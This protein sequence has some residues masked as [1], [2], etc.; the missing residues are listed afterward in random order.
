[1]SEAWI[2]AAAIAVLL[3]LLAPLAR[4]VR[5]QAVMIVAAMSMMLAC[6][7]ALVLTGEP[8]RG[9]HGLFPVAPFAILWPV[10]LRRAWERHD[11][12]LLALGTA[13]WTYLLFIFAALALTYIHKGLLDVGMQW[14]Q[15]YLL[16]AYPMLAILSLVALRALRASLPPGGLRLAC[17][18]LFALLVAAGVS[19]EIRGVRMLHG[20]RGIMAQWDAAMRSEGPIVTTVWWI[21]PA[22]ADLFLTHE[23]FF[24][25]PA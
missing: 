13:T 22:V 12:A 7:A 15:R 25:W 9:L 18:T 23:M 8:Y 24:T 10:A 4:S 17:V 11:S 21:V 5:V 6:S 20:T 1:V 19:L 3:G 16:T 14:G 2:A